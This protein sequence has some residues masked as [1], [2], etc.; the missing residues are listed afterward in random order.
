MSSLDNAVKMIGNLVVER[1]DSTGA[2]IEMQEY[3]N[4][5]VSVGKAHIASRMLGTTQGSMSHMGI[6][7][8]ATAP[9]A[10]D[11]ALGT[12]VG[13]R[14]TATSTQG[15]G[16]TANQI[17]YSATFPAN[18][19]STQQTIAEAGIFNASTAGTMLCHTALSPTVTKNPTDSITITWTVTVG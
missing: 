5:V 12:E 4:L 7:T 8:N 16:A 14:A 10:S 13:T 6:G 15:T 9:A 18:N 1:F 3:K 17:T 11:T 19:P 2:L